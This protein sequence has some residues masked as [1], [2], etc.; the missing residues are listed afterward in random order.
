MHSH[1]GQVHAVAIYIY[2]A[3]GILIVMKK[4]ECTQSKPILR[5]WCTVKIMSY[6]GIYA[7]KVNN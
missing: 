6:H 4:M 5:V 3:I 1:D 2:I 7:I